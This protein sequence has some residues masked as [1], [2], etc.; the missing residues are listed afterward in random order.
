MRKL[1]LLLLAFLVLPAAAVAQGAPIRAVTVFNQQA[2]T[3]T[4]SSVINNRIAKATTHQ[5]I[6]TKTGGDAG[7]IG[8]DVTLQ[9]R[10]GTA[11]FANIGLTR[12]CPIGTTDGGIIIF[13]RPGAAVA[14]SFHD[15][16]R[17]VVNV[18]DGT[19]TFTVIY[20]GYHTADTVPL[21]QTTTT[22]HLEVAP[23]AAGNLP[24]DNL[25]NGLFRFTR[26]ED[27]TVA[28]PAIGLYAFDGTSWD[29]VRVENGVL[30]T[31]D[32]G[33]KVRSVAGTNP[34]AGI[35]ISETVPAS[36]R[37]KL[38]SVFFRLVTSATAATRRLHFVVDDG[39][40]KLFDFPVGN[41]HLAS[42]TR[43]YTIAHVGN[44]GNGIQDDDIMQILPA[45]AV[46]PTGF[47]VRTETT[48]I[49]VG[50]DFGAPQL[51]VEECTEFIP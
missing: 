22:G 12:T 5:V 2:I 29:R 6:A 47:R 27:G 14:Q 39:T 25:T 18:T 4:V 50:D 43:D 32:H 34:A 41:T 33:C 19:A 46:L 3:G 28:A 7:I 8:C 36:V 38:I 49:Q 20:F 37:W 24:A 15:D 9:G 26:V 40:N 21:L 42:L 35:E 1:F 10:V 30:Y 16:L 13:E 51:W 45:D 48:G 44:V 31:A 23:L 17:V 11:A